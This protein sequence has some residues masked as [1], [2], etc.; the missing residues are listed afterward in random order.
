MFKRKLFPSV[1]RSQ[2][3][4]RG[5]LAKV[6]WKINDSINLGLNLWRMLLPIFM[7]VWLRC[8]KIFKVAII[9]KPLMQLS[10]SFIHLKPYIWNHTFETKQTK[11]EQHFFIT[12]INFFYLPSATRKFSL[13]HVSQLLE[14]PGCFSIT[15][16]TI[17]VSLNCSLVHSVQF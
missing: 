1:W 9:I 17:T 8:R 6:A 7:G 3:V 12:D 11:K 13:S 5:N 15:V 10:C 2:F 16:I 4:Y 14:V